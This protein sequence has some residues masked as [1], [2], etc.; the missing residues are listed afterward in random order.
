LRPI[1]VAGPQLFSS[2]SPHFASSMTFDVTS[3][4][5]LYRIMGRS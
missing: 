4:S 5:R 1:I 3:M 2:F